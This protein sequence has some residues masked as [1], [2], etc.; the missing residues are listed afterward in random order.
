M[1]KSDDL[2]CFSVTLSLSCL[3]SYECVFYVPLA[4]ATGHTQKK[5]PSEPKFDTTNQE[6]NKHVAAAHGTLNTHITNNSKK[7]TNDNKVQTEQK[8]ENIA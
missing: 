3:C 5:E 8:L 1:H 4:P 7:V 6:K 2:V